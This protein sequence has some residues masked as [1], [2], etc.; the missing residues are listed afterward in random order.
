MSHQ[1][2]L[3]I[4]S[5]LCV[6]SYPQSVFAQVKPSN[7]KAEQ[8]LSRESD[9]DTKVQK[10]IGKTFWINPNPKAIGRVVFYES[11]TEDAV[12]FTVDKETSFIA[13]GAERSSHF[14]FLTV[15]F[16]E[17]K[18]GYLKLN[19]AN[20]G[21]EKIEKPIEFLLDD[22]TVISENQEYIFPILPSDFMKSYLAKRKKETKEAQSKPSPRIG[23]SAAQVLASN[24]GEPES[25]NTTITANGNSEQWVYGLRMYIYFRNGRVSAIQY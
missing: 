11:P 17:G 3:G 25:I 1:F 4:L 18:Y 20:V 19:W 2:I 16:L 24:W 12:T 22:R 5:V 21:T 8:Q 10:L 14:K 6:I 13:T 15:V 23:M 9:F 7:L